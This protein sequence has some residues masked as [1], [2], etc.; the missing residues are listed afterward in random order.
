MGRTHQQLAQR[1]HECSSRPRQVVQKNYKQEGYQNAPQVLHSLGALAGSSRGRHTVLGLQGTV[2]K[3]AVGVGSARK[4]NNTA[5]AVGLCCELVHTEYAW[6][7]C[8]DGGVQVLVE[9]AITLLLLQ[10]LR[11]LRGGTAVRGLRLV[12]LILRYA[13]LL[14][15]SNK[16]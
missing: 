14:S 13:V 16:G 8:K 7:S 11:S 1:L 10:S 2:W 15:V 6:T 5:Q 9:V 12:S 3:G 4:L